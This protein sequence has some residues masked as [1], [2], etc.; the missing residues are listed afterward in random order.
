ASGQPRQLGRPGERAGLGVRRVPDCGCPLGDQIRVRAGRVHDDVEL[1][2]QRAEVAPGQRPVRLLSQQGQAYHVDQRV[3]QN[4]T[5]HLSGLVRQGRTDGCHSAPPHRLAGTTKTAV[6]YAQISVHVLLS[7]RWS[8]RIPTTAF[9]PR[10]YACSA[11]RAIA[12]SRQRDR[13][14][15]MR[16][17]MPPLS[18]LTPSVKAFNGRAVA[19]TTPPSTSF[20]SKPGSVSVVTTSICLLPS[21][22]FPHPG[23][24]CVSWSAGADHLAGCGVQPARAGGCPCA[25]RQL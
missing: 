4:L 9:A 6:P 1:Q 16:G 3:L 12:S 8:N 14:C 22:C 21:L 11:S 15:G 2:V 13:V 17:S 19:P 7:G 10:W 23:R 24:L 18:A 20:T 5:G 25:A